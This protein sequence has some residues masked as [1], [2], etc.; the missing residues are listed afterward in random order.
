MISS[1]SPDLAPTSSAMILVTT[2]L[3]VS[4]VKVIVAI[5]EELVLLVAAL[6]V[7]VFSVFDSVQVIV[8]SEVSTSLPY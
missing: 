5:P 4:V 3:T 6:K 8:I 1:V 2:S 7:P